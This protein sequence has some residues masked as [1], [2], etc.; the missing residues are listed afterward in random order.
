[1][2]HYHDIARKYFLVWKDSGRPKHGKEY[3]DMKTSRADFKGA[4]NRCKAN[5]KM[6]RNKKLLDKLRN[7]NYKEFWS[8]VHSIKK[9]NDPQVIGIDGMYSNIDIANMFSSKYKRIFNKENNN[10]NFKKHYNLKEDL[11]YSSAP[12]IYKKKYQHYL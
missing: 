1:M 12:S 3:E 4:L 5:E 6:H 11:V 7:K 10:E 2:K 9:H 8:D